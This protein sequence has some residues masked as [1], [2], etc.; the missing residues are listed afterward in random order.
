MK[1]CRECGR[2]LP[3]EQFYRHA[4]MADGRLNKCKECVK[5]RVSK[6]RGRNVERIRKYDRERSKAPVA[7]KRRAEY[8]Q[9]Y[10]RQN[11]MRYKATTAVGNAIRDGRLIKPSQCSECGTPGPVEAHH[12]DYSR[13]LDVVWLCSVCHS[14]K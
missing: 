10:R 2:E 12:S 14:Q 3:E 7:R 13:P 4:A 5:R 6:H 8:C 9:E 11:P 1:I